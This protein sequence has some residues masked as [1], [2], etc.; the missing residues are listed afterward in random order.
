MRGLDS[1]LAHLSALPGRAGE[2]ALGAAREAAAEAALQAR[3][4]APVQTGALRASLSAVFREDGAEAKT[5]CPYAALVE[6][7]TRRTPARPFLLPAARGADYFARA[8]RALRE[9]V[10]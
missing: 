9:A 3:A 1:A 4:A 7:G 8:A 5:A 6:G 2:A 10:K